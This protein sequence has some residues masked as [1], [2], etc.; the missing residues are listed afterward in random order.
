[1]FIIYILQPGSLRIN[2]KKLCDSS[3]EMPKLLS[4]DFIFNCPGCAFGFISFGVEG[5]K[6]LWLMAKDGGERGKVT[7]RF[8]DY[9]K[10]FGLCLL[11]SVV[12]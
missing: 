3:L 8:V 5:R 10:E 2:E 9:A 11:F 6:E 12:L 7:G 1:M 4:C